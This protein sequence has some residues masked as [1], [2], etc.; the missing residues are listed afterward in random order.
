MRRPPQ[1]GKKAKIIRETIIFANN[2]NVQLADFD[3]SNF[4]LFGD[5]NK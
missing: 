3:W 1:P 4:N 2:E 5:K